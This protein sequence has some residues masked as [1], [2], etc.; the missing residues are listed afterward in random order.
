MPTW[1]IIVVTAA[2]SYLLSL[3]VRV[4]TSREKRIEY[5][6]E[7]YLEWGWFVPVLLVWIGIVFWAAL[8]V[9]DQN[10]VPPPLGPPPEW[11]TPA[12]VGIT[13]LGAGLGW[14]VGRAPWTAFLGA[15]LAF[16]LS[17]TLFVW[18]HSRFSRRQSNAEPVAS[19]DPAT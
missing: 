17:V 6:I 16:W 8:D 14:V 9:R 10:P 7:Q 18:L 1:L 15:W 5:R 3:V 12:S 4:L 11:T 13:A 2:A 19:P